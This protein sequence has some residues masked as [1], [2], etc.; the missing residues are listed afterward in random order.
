MLR[1]LQP[2]AA[3]AATAP[4]QLAPA[5]PGNAAPGETSSLL[6]GLH[7]DIDRML[8]T[9]EALRTFHSD[10]KQTLKDL[11]SI[12]MLPEVTPETAAL[13]EP[14]HERAEGQQNELA[15]A[16]SGPRVPSP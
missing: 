15:P 16:C 8:K 3:V 14:P 5:D 7:V 1:H 11:Q 2:A 13:Q 10:T 12:T 6:Q 4:A 9:A